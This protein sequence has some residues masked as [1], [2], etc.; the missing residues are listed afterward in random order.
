VAEIEKGDVHLRIDHANLGRSLQQVGYCL[1][2]ME[3]YAEAR[4][5]FERAVAE[6]GKGDMHGRID[7]ET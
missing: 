4:P 2:R 3:R 5:W 1:S 7:H 6:K